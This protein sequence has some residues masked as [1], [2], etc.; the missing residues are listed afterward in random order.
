ML[1]L[2]VTAAAALVLGFV[3]GLLTFKRSTG[4]CSECG[5][6]LRC[7]EC[8]GHSTRRPALPVAGGRTP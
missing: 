4:W 2:I 7:T 5:A 3:T 1:A 8:L 6:I